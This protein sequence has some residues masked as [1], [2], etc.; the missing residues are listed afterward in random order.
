MVE[1]C[2]YRKMVFTYECQHC[3]IL[4]RPIDALGMHECRTHPGKLSWTGMFNCCNTMQTYNTIR[5]LGC[6]PADHFNININIPVK[7]NIRDYIVLLEQTKTNIE[8]F[9]T[10]PGVHKH[11]DGNIYLCT[12]GTHNTI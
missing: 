6:T 2:L 12:I 7:S 10:R 8:N 3:G 9:E 11:T 5:G 4:Y 1:S